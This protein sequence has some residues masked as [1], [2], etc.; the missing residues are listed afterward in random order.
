MQEVI[1]TCSAFAYGG[2]GL[3]RLADGRVVF[4][5]FALPGERVR[6]RLV[7]E[8]A[9]YAEADLLEVLMP[10]PERITPRCGHYMQCG[11]CPYQH[12]AAK[13]QILY[14]Q[15]VRLGGLVDPPVAPAVPSPQPWHYRNHMQFHLLA[16]GRLGLQAAHTQQS[17]ALQECYLPEPALDAAWRGY[18]TRKAGKRETRKQG[19]G[20][21]KGVDTRRVS[22][23]V[24]TDG[25]LQSAGGAALTIQVLDRAFRVS[26]ESFFQVNTPMAA[27]MVQHLL[28]HLPLSS[29]AVALD[30]YCGVGLFSA[31]LAP[32][33][34]RL[35]GIES[36]PSACD[37]FAV[38]LADAHNVT[39]YRA[40][41]EQ[42]LAQIKPPIDLMLV[43]P[44]RA[45]I[46]QA[47]VAQILRL[48]P[49]TLAYISCDPA[50]LARDA[51]QL[52][53]GGYQLL[54]STP[55]DLFPQ[56]YHIESISFWRQQAIDH[57]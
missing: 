17:V 50:T 25:A 39:L 9:G 52:L 5:P 55:F 47:V 28:S 1:V 14:E 6:I 35:I 7:K 56:T 8:K 3:A 40:P 31:F 2:Q 49:T 42:A 13:A 21:R 15:L 12:L 43:D 26:P 46:G 18:Q 34:S 24:G 16:D 33:V 27:Q 51:R 45:G 41:A 36:A 29:Q 4:V 37:D 54:H 53:A 32:R 20:E 10:A 23:R 44:P 38:N 57:S 30:V 22:L 48:A 19:S 11:G